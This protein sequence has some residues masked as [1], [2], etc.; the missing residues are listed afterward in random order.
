MKKTFIFGATLLFAAAAGFFLFGEGKKELARPRFLP[1]GGS[2]FAPTPIPTPTPVVP[3]A[4]EETTVIYTDAGYTPATVRVKVGETVVFQNSSSRSIWPA[5]GLHP[6]HDVY[7]IKGGCISS[8][9]DACKGIKSGESWSFKFSEVGTWKYHDH[10]NPS[11]R[12][13]VEVEK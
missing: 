8:A 1:Q 2:S 12:G 13:V 6:T 10:L 4:A 11:D 7:P 3:S 5:S 9:F